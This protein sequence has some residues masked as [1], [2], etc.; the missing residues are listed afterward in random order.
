MNTPIGAP[1]KVK[2][3]VKG[4]CMQAGETLLTTGRL[5]ASYDWLPAPPQD[6]KP[7]SLFGNGCNDPR[8]YKLAGQVTLQSPF[9]QP[10]WTLAT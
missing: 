10:F 3:S 8:P 9:S 1:W 6:A 4:S 7:L 5:D 2:K